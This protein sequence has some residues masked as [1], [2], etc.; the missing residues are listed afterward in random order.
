LQN[1]AQSKSQLLYWREGVKKLQLR[2][3]Y[4]ETQKID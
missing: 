3:H 4:N 2:Y 1:Q